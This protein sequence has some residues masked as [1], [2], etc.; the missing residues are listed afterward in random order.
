MAILINTEPPVLF[1][2]FVHNFHS[3]HKIL[4]LT[5]GSFVHN[6]SAEIDVVIITLMQPAMDK[7]PDCAVFHAVREQTSNPAPGSLQPN[8]EAKGNS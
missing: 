3:W 7:G 8:Y 1:L 6:T 5:L 2:E 4:H